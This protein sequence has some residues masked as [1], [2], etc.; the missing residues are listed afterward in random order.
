MVRSS[1]HYTIWG[2]GKDCKGTAAEDLDDKGSRLP[3]G[4]DWSMQVYE[5]D[6]GLMDGLLAQHF[7]PVKYELEW[8]PVSFEGCYQLKHLKAPKVKET[9]DGWDVPARLQWVARNG[10][11]RFVALNHN[12][13]H[14][15][16]S[17]ADLLEF[18]WYNARAKKWEREDGEKRPMGGGGS[19][20]VYVIPE[21]TYQKMKGGR[22]V[23][24]MGWPTEGKLFDYGCWK[25]SK[26]NSG[27]DRL[28]STQMPNV[29]SR[30]SVKACA[31]AAA[32]R[33]A[34]WFGV[35]GNN[36]IDEKDCFIELQESNIAS[37]GYRKA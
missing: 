9:V 10:H 19:C 20:A 5:V 29:K 11:G 13:I 36:T 31:V 18:S 24:P 16:S 12:D 25:D 2:P 21:D 15:G 30:G 28:F 22:G 4:G 6:A 26:G 3:T 27:R 8:G 37:A 17:I 1:S 34:L 14:T 32:K 23:Q 33:G 7:A 35:E